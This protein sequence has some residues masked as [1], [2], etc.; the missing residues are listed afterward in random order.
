MSISF[1]FREEESPS[2]GTIRRPVAKVFFHHHT[3]DIW[4][5]VRMIIDTGADYTLLPRFL[6]PLL[7][8]N[9]EKDCKTIETRGVGGRTHVY[10]FNGK[11]PVRI[12]IY[13]RKIPLGFL[14]LDHIPPL[15]GRLEFFETFRVVFHKFT[16]TFQ[17]NEGNGRVAPSPTGEP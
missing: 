1:P 7:G 14:P 4:Q 13:E 2:F 5:P 16:T 6:A 12:G 9:L 3:D 17:D 8:I 11:L 15:L 10:L